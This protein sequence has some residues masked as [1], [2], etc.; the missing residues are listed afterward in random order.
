[1]SARARHLGTAL[2]RSLKQLAN[3]GLAAWPHS[4]L[5]N[6]PK[7]WRAQLQ[8]LGVLASKNE[9]NDLLSAIMRTADDS[10][11]Q[12]ILG[13]HS[14]AYCEQSLSYLRND[15]ESTGISIIDRTFVDDGIRWII[16]YKLTRPAVQETN[17]EFEQRQISYYKGQLNHYASLYKKMGS[18]PVRCAL[19]FPQIG[20][21]S[22]VT[23]E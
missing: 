3:E 20:M 8:E 19:Y 21:F 7:T 6:L 17:E 10:T 14:S 15:G 12:W 1:M 5:L 11:G 18:E 16:D 9:L 2:H 22:Q 4:R 13:Q 23:V